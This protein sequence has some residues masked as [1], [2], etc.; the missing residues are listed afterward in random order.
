[1]VPNTIAGDFVKSDKRIIL[2]CPLAGMLVPCII[3]KVLRQY[4]PV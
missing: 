1:M 3:A 4:L 2:Y